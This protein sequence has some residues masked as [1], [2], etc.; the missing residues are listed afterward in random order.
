MLAY[1]WENF[2]GGSCGLQ[3]IDVRLNA[4]SVLLVLEIGEHLPAI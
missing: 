2:F 1:S 3:S 4:D